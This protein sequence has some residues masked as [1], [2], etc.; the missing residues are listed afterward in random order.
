MNSLFGRLGQWFTP[1]SKRPTKLGL[2]EVE[3]I[4][5]D[6]FFIYFILFILLSV[7]CGR[8]LWI[9]GYLKWCLQHW[10]KWH[11]VS[12][13]LQILCAIV[14]DV[15]DWDRCCQ[16]FFLCSLECAK[17]SSTLSKVQDRHGKGR[18]SK[19]WTKSWNS[20]FELVEGTVGQGL[21]EVDWTFCL[22]WRERKTSNLPAYIIELNTHHV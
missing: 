12:V 20:Q 5:V 19:D 9:V 18:K 4:W 14:L 21:A 13:I 6:S 1:N 22:S 17:L 8:E 10:M 15:Y 2:I 16:V 11:G 3:L 7:C